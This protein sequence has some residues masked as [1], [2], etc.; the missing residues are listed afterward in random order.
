MYKKLKSFVLDDAV[1]MALLLILVGVV[2]FG[3]GRQSVTSVSVN[4]AT[5]SGVT[6]LNTA[7]EP[8]FAQPKKPAQRVVASKSGTKYHLLNCPGAKQIKN[9]N[10][11]F[12]DAP[13]LAEAAGYTPAA[14]CEGL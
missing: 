6:V 11:V 4:A 2:S 12:F 3:L 14:N 10:K 5:V 7:S 13:S 1:Y 8:E 9:E